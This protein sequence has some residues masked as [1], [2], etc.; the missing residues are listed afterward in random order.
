MGAEGSPKEALVIGE[1]NAVTI[2]KLLDESSR[3]LD[4]GEEKR[5]RASRYLCHAARSV[6]PRSPQWKRPR[7]LPSERL[8][9]VRLAGS[10]IPTQYEDFVRHV[11]TR[12]R[13]RTTAPEPER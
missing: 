11:L 13:P 10:L 1:H 4:V 8:S 7:W 2:A 5:D 12:A 6:T 9:S 3:P